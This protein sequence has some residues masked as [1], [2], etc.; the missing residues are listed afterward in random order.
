MIERRLQGEPLA[1]IIQRREFFSLDF[2]VDRRVLIPRPES[3]LLVE[4]A[5]KLASN[6]S[7]PVLA[8]VGT[9]SGCIAISLAANL[10]GGK[11]YASDI[12]QAA[13]EVAC[14]NS[15]KHGVREKVNLLLGDLLEP[16]P[17]AVD[18]LIANLPYV[19]SAD[20]R[21]MPSARFEPRLA[22]DGGKEGLDQLRR[23]NQQLKGKLRAGG[24]VLQEVGLGQSAQ[25]AS[26]LKGEFPSA[27]IAVL[28]DL[29]GIDRMVKMT[30]PDG[31]ERGAQSYVK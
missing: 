11:V 5:L 17:E 4:E 26:W 21:R 10:P 28:K 14:I 30:L 12:S 22:L 2:Y 3:E 27:T 19:A 25:V 1:Y 7:E 8:D 16:L 23:F 20:A 6:Y 18:I 29:A 15:H 24:T 13:L 31:Q 9:G